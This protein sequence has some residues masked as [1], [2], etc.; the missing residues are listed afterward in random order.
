[1]M[2]VLPDWYTKGKSRF[3]DLIYK[4]ALEQH[5][6][7]DFI[8]D[9]KTIEDSISSILMRLVALDERV[10]L[11]DRE[12]LKEFAESIRPKKGRKNELKKTKLKGKNKR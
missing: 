8:E 10:D 9:S 7:I 3:K 12:R 5:L 2:R 4:I 1:M 11:E 6:P